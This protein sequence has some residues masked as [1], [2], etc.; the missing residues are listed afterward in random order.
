MNEKII[1]LKNISHTEDNP[2]MNIKFILCISV[3]QPDPHY[4][5]VSYKK[6]DYYGRMLFIHDK[7]ERT[8]WDDPRIKNR[9]Q[10]HRCK[11]RYPI[12]YWTNSEETQLIMC[13]F[14]GV[15]GI[16]ELFL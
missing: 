15:V 1:R 7:A 2:I 6:R 9:H 11:H 14:R 12:I 16:V 8:T 10:I 13:L 5:P 3:L 4:P